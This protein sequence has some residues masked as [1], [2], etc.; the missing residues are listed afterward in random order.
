M[1]LSQLL[2]G[3]EV[4]EISN[5]MD[6]EIENITD[7]SFDVKEN[8]LFCCIVGEKIDAHLLMPDLVKKGCKVFLVEKYNTSLL[9]IVIQIKVK[10]VRQQMCLLISNF[11]NNA[12][13][14]MQLIGVTGTNGKT[15]ITFILKNSFEILKQKVGIIGT[16]GCYIGSEKFE[17]N[18]TTPDPIDLH[19]I[20]FKMY[21]MGVEIVVMEV[22]A[23]SIFLDKIYGLKF[24]YGIFTNLTQDH[25]DFFKT[26]KNY[27][28]SKIKFLKEYCQTAIINIDD[29]YGYKL[30][31]LKNSIS[32]AI[33]KKAKFNAKL[34]KMQL[35]KIDFEVI[36]N[37]KKYK[38]N[39]PSSGVH[40]VY[41][42]LSCIAL[43]IDYGFK[44]KQIKQAIAKTPVIKGRFD[45]IKINQYFVCIDYAHTP[46]ALLNVLKSLRDYTKDLIVIFGS[47]GNRDSLK[48]KEMGIIV[49]NFADYIILTSDNPRYENEKDI[50]YD[51]SNGITKPYVIEP[52]RAKAIAYAGNIAN[53]NSI[54]LICG[55]GVETYQD[56]KANK[57]EYSDYIE[58]EKLKQ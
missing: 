32:Y 20:F 27:A 30:K 31:N 26:M 47:S 34:I 48:R 54:I 36:S 33:N 58:V 44:T 15:S 51:L 16:T 11:Y 45:V 13:K 12:H 49:S 46:D 24:K 8:S 57:I 6:L 42:V 1:K 18:L 10:N 41:N 35:S 23:H 21:E 43:L 40:N 39:Y 5:F 56:I 29:K 2:N 25:L 38:F 9:D 22:S 28:E 17:T 19:R 3:L 53:Y 7:K 50:I 52:N 4:L 37:E 14:K 55:K